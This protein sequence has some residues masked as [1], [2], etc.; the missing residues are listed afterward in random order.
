MPYSDPQNKTWAEEKMREMN[1]ETVLDVGAGAGTYGLMARSINPNARIDGIEV[2]TPYI[3]QFGLNNIYDHVYNY[4][5][6]EHKVWTYDLVIFGDILEHMSK[7]DAFDLYEKAAKY[8][9]YILFSIPIVHL[10][11]G[12][13]GGNPYETHVVDHWHHED[14]LKEFRNLVDFATFPVTGI[15]LAKF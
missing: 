10:P 9:T 14:I 6:K 3:D 5:A 1:F 12:A 11:Q 2:W 8:C 13:W 15:Y 4:E 7:Q